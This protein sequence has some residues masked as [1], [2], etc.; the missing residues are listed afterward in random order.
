MPVNASSLESR[1]GENVRVTLILEIGLI[2]FKVGPLMVHFCWYSGCL[3]KL[4][5]TP[6]Y[7]ASVRRPDITV[8]MMMPG[9]GSLVHYS[10]GLINT[11]NTP[12][13]VSW[14]TR[15]GR[16]PQSRDDRDEFFADILSDGGMSGHCPGPGTSSQGYLPNCH[17]SCPSLPLALTHS[18]IPG[19]NPEQCILASHWSLSVNKAL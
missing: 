3:A 9:Q 7:A 17:G 12:R 18:K 10:G 1:E 13:A 11:V 5:V 8:T 6:L 19:E 2:F 14:L 4:L 15:P 16:H